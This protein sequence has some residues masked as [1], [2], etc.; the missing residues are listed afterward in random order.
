M[1]GIP[2]AVLIVVAVGL[3]LWLCGIWER[4]RAMAMRVEDELEVGVVEAP[5]AGRNFERRFTTAAEWEPLEE[6]VAL[7]VLACAFLDAP[8][9]IEAMKEGEIKRTPFAEY[10]LVE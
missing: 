4:R 10:R 3:W 1:T 9:V 7:R 2:D 8:R 6:E 5:A